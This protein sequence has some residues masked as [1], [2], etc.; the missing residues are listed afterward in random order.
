MCYSLRH[1]S[2]RRTLTSRIIRPHK[3]KFFTAQMPRGE[4]LKYFAKDDKGLYVGTE[5]LRLWTEEEVE[6]K[7]G[8][9]R[10]LKEKGL[11]EPLKSVINAKK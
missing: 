6:L 3:T 5:P 7:F 4:Y 11:F 8:K 10:T 9:Y 2:V 1:N